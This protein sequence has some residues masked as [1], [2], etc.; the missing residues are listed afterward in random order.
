MEYALFA[1]PIY[2][3]KSAAART[4]LAKLETER[5]SA[6]AA[7]EQRLGITRELWAIQTTP[8]GEL[9]VVFFQAD[10]IPGAVRQFVESRD[11]FDLW[12]KQQVNDTT[13]VDLNVQPNGALSEIL[14]IYNASAAEAQHKTQF[15]A[16]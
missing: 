1:L 16:A 7:S 9:F 11:Q 6:Y 10:D 12:F 14:S 13:G 2:G 8:E 4:F 5:K 15:T 3:G